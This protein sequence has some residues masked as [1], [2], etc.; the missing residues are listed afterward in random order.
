MV[1][2]GRVGEKSTGAAAYVAASMWAL[3]AIPIWFA[4]SS[5]DR[6]PRNNGTKRIGR[7]TLFYAMMAQ[8]FISICTICR[9]PPDK[10][11]SASSLLFD[12]EISDLSHIVYV[13]KHY[14]F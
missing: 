3:I 10:K 8:Y 14:L 13:T 2:T 5:D 6:P 4:D 1:L 9:R 12:I 11:M 7:M